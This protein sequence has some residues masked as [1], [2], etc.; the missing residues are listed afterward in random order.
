MPTRKSAR[1][2][3]SSPRP[4]DGNDAR[5]HRQPRQADRLRRHH[6]PQGAE[7][8]RHRAARRRADLGRRRRHERARRRR[9]VE[10]PRTSPPAT[11]PW[12][13][14][15]TKTVTATCDLG[16]QPDSLAKSADGK[17]LAI[18]IENERDEEV[19]DG[20][21]PQLPGGNL[22]VFAARPTALSIAPPEVIVDL[23]GL[24]AIAP[25]RSRA[26]TGR[27]QRHERGRRDAPGEQPHR[28]RRSRDRQGRRRISRPAASISPASTP[29]RTASSPS[30]ARRTASPREPDAVQWIDDDRFV[31]A[32]EGDLEGGSRGFTIF[33]KDGTVDYESGTAFEHDHRPPRPLSRE[34]ATRR[35]AS[36][37]APKSRPSATTA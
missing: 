7:G 36:R 25:G 8:R 20:A 34:A 10:S 2:P 27:H 19:N 26:R 31:T 24:A 15:A 4:P 22:T 14:V 6:R 29:R 35:A 11:S 9:H 28:H 37:R 21:I 30:P 33:N 12:S 3:R 23:T 16:G 32:N 5:L 18:A 17:F 1:L 13:I